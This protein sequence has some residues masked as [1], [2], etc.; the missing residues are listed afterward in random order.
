MVCIVGTAAAWWF[1]GLPAFLA[2]IGI[3]L[4]LS[5]L[6]E[7]EHDLI[8][9]LYFADRP[10]VQNLM[11][12]GIWMAKMSLNPWARRRIHRY[13]HQV[14]GQPEDIEERLIGLGLPWGLQR[15]VLS[16][17]PA[18]SVTL[19]RTIDRDVRNAVRE[20]A[21]APDLNHARGFVLLRGVDTV[22]FLTPFVV[23]PMALSG[24]AWAVS[25]LVLWVLPNT[26]RHFSIVVVSSNSHYT[27]I[28]RSELWF[29][30]QVLDHWLTWPLQLFCFHFGA[31]HILHHYVVKQPFW[32]RQLVAPRVRPVLRA[33]G[34]Q[35]NDLGTFA[36]ANRHP[37]ASA[38]QAH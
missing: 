5:V 6:H 11:F 4:A 27:H 35:F 14:S 18:G 23:V 34:V 30:N 7:L 28:P 12:A 19:A 24:A 20:G 31:T 33:N 15:L 8:H 29:Q 13:H 36:R 38:V 9:D 37:D 22:F 2:V 3:A 26:I 1:A 16:V 10:W 25:L 17:L 32:L 21:V